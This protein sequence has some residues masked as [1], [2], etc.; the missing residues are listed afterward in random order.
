MKFLRQ[1]FL[2]ILLI[3]AAGLWVYRDATKKGVC[4]EP[5]KYAIG[6]FDS[7]FKISKADFKS[8]V[9][10]AAGIWEK[11]TGKNLFEYD[12]NS[13]P[14]GPIYTYIGK[15][16]TRADIPVNLV[17]DTRQATSDKNRNLQSELN[18]QKQTLDEMRNELDALKARYTTEVASYQNLLSDYRRHKSSYD[19]VEA[20]RQVVNS[21]VN[22]INSLA[23]K[24]NS[25]VGI[26]NTVV[27]T[28]NQT[29]GQEFEE[30]QYMS[31]ANGERINIFEFG[32]RQDLVRVLAH[33]FGHALGLDH[34]GNPDSI[35][36]YLNNSSNTKPT[37]E[38]L[39][40][41]SIVCKGS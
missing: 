27:K 18:N 3:A 36:Y 4:D 39:S 2:W 40:A 9:D 1:S 15:Y 32:T 25:T 8:A 31:D 20:E 10:E 41:V 35:M 11:A 21:L 22:Q 23:Q 7:R 33:E 5:I 13:A 34:N 14:T 38:D 6:A 37:K 26:Y 17:Y 12:S 19:D 16:F 24:T 28:I 30:G 29:A